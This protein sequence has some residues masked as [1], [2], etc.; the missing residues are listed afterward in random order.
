MGE[1]KSLVR[2]AGR[3]LVAHALSV[4]RQ[5]GL[6]ASIAGARSPL[7]GFAPVI[8]DAQPDLGPLRGICAALEST[9][10]PRAVF[11]PVDMP[12]LPSSLIAFLVDHAQITGSAVTVF[13]LNGFA[14]TFPAIV[15]RAAMPALVNELKAGRGGCFSSFQAASASLGQ[16]M[17]VVPVELL[18]QAGHVAHPAGLAAAHWFENINSPADLR[19]AEALSRPVIA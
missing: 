2:F 3:P 16:P 11:L 17:T 1:D 19:R 4:L 13:S 5:A 8:E 10:A 18:V 6:A 14:Q 7:A 15:D 12:L 9:R